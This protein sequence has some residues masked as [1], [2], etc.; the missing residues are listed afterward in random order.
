MPPPVLPLTLRQQDPTALKVLFPNVSTL[1]DIVIIDDG[2][3]GGPV[4]YVWNIPDDFPT[5][6]ALDAA[7]DS[8]GRWGNVDAQ[9]LEAL[10]FIVQIWVRCQIAAVAFPAAWVTYYQDWRDIHT[11]PFPPVIPTQPPIPP[12]V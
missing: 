4:L 1:T 6:A 12:G 7:Y 5:N 8:T 3:G 10:A 2:Q 11:Q 9:R